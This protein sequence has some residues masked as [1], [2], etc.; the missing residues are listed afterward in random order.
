MIHNTQSSQISQKEDGR[1]T[2]AIMKTICSL[3]YHHNCLVA[4]HTLGHMM[5]GCANVVITGRTISMG[6]LFELYELHIYLSV[7]KAD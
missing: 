5:Y 7:T 6:A 1:N 2:Y 3:G 4:T